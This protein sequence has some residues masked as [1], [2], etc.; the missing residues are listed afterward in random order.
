MQD[1]SLTGRGP[2]VASTDQYPWVG[3]EAWTHHDRRGLKNDQ[4]GIDFI[5]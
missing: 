4:E 3:L 5:R 2:P 1:V